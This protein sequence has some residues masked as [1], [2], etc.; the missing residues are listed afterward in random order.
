MAVLK[1]CPDASQSSSDPWYLN[2]SILPSVWSTTRTEKS[3]PTVGRYRICLDCSSATNVVGSKTYV[4]HLDPLCVKHVQRETRQA[5]SVYIIP[6]RLDSVWCNTVVNICNELHAIEQFIRKCADPI[7]SGMLCV[8]IGRSIVAEP[9][10]ENQL[11]LGHLPERPK[12][13]EITNEARGRQR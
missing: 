4:A 3:L 9:I 6:V 1:S 10:R 13:P 8:T 12:L 2:V 11:S 7:D 5:G